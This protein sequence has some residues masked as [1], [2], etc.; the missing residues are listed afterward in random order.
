M[1][2]E[3]P[4]DR[5]GI[6][7]AIL[8]VA[9]TLMAAAVGFLFA[10]ASNEGEKA[11][12]KA[13]EQLVKVQVVGRQVERQTEAQL[14][15]YE[16][17]GEQTARAAHAQQQMRF[18]DPQSRR[19][20]RAEWRR[21][22]RAADRTDQELG[23]MA[24][25]SELLSDIRPAG[26]DGVDN[27]PVFPFRMRQRSQKRVLLALGRRDAAN[28]LSG[29]WGKRAASYTAV[30]TLLAVALY[31]FGFSVTPH[32]RGLR[33][34]YALVALVLLS[35]GVAFGPLRALSPPR[36]APDSA[37]ADYAEG[38]TLLRTGTR[39]AHF[40]RG[41]ERLDSAI[42][43]R[44]TFADAYEARVL[45]R[46]ARDTPQYSLFT[47][48]LP[49]A[50]RRA[51]V[52]DLRLVRS[53][54]VETA[55]L[56]SSLGFN[57]LVLGLEEDRQE[58]IAES[59]EVTRESLSR[60]PEEIVTIFNLGAA[61][62][63]DGQVSEARAEYRRAVALTLKDRLKP[64]S[65]AEA[66]ASAALTDLEVI[67]Q[68]GPAHLLPE[69]LEMQEL[70]IGSLELGRVGTGRTKAG[71]SGTTATVL[72]GTVKLNAEYW[73]GLHSNPGLGSS[74]PALNVHWYHRD[75]EGVGWSHVLPVSGLQLT[76]NDV[77]K[78]LH[79]FADYLNVTED[80]C[81]GP[82]RYRVEVF[83]RGNLIGEADTVHDTRGRAVAFRDHLSGI[84]GCRPEH[85][86]S[87]SAAGGALRGFRSRD[88]TR[89]MYLLR[90]DGALWKD[91][92][93][94]QTQSRAMIERVIARLP[95]EFPSPSRQA[96][97][98]LRTSNFA[99]LER[100]RYRGGTVIAGAIVD[101]DDSVAIGLVFGPDSFFESGLQ[102]PERLMGSLTL[103]D[104]PAASV[105][106]R[107]EADE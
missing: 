53:L 10:M 68:H 100:Y 25:R 49:R 93:A 47:S 77:D 33:G 63:A 88:G 59:I 50:S 40:E 17:N 96:R 83:D 56:L 103:L 85:W 15:L 101:Y 95:A 84:G 4:R 105:A 30:L 86:E 6:A 22:S 37:A 7:I 106:V 87:V 1:S 60:D 31:L 36:E 76:K 92:P 27:D 20:H 41:V 71:V 2:A 19:E 74:D 104:P 73:E 99:P 23:A 26:K 102:E 82:G 34:P 51:S 90:L 91:T 61:L 8:S 5:F 13:Q 70:I 43:K 81:L 79:T 14:R 29:S 65:I 28:E 58:L 75:P 38:L 16:L 72:P 18:G 3:K 52:R 44:E 35:L 69:V 66:R 45:G 48:L 98:R 97:Q 24:A 67:S 107:E 21:W 9:T 12:S 39:P 32:A 64:G 55:P 94:R 11:A 89:G 62:L 80:H 42:E 54:G 57:L 78:T 46:L